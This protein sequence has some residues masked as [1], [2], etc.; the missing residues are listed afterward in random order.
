MSCVKRKTRFCGC[1]KKVRHQ[2]AVWGLRAAEPFRSSLCRKHC[3]Q[4]RW[5]QHER[6]RGPSPPWTRR[7]LSP[8]PRWRHPENKRG[9]SNAAGRSL[10]PCTTIRTM[11]VSVQQCDCDSWWQNSGSWRRIACCFALC[12][13]LNFFFALRSPTTKRD[14]TKGCRLQWQSELLLQGSFTIFPP[15]HKERLCLFLVFEVG[16]QSVQDE[17][18]V[19]HER[20]HFPPFDDDALVVRF[21]SLVQVPQC[22]VWGWK[23]SNTTDVDKFLKRP[24]TQRAR[25][26]IRC[27][28]TGHGWRRN[29]HIQPPQRARCCSARL[30]PSWCRGPVLAKSLWRPSTGDV[31]DTV[32]VPAFQD[33][34][35]TLKEVSKDRFMKKKI[36]PKQPANS[37][38][39]WLSVLTKIWLKQSNRRLKQVNWIV[40]QTSKT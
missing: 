12:L 40:E 24:R 9:R 5:R 11:P 39:V 37:Q 36:F 20:H 22:S 29:T 3:H 23:V 10:P 31:R 1:A 34:P 32:Q 19:M 7:P 16:L 6:R 25:S 4:R 13:F 8:L 30:F 15:Y 27:G 21:L 14:K 26:L 28:Y 18:W 38:L 33:T 35:R 2:T 17:R